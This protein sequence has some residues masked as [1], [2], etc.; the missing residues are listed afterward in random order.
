MSES[1][2]EGKEAGGPVSPLLLKVAALG[3]GGGGVYLLAG[4]RT[5]IEV[6]VLLMIVALAAFGVLLGSGP[7]GPAA[8]GALDLSARLGLGLLGGFLGALAAVAGR[9]VLVAAGLPELL[10][11]SLFTSWTAPALLAHLG[12]GV[13]WGMVLGIVFPY[14]PG[15][16]AAGQGALFS[17]VPSLYLL[18]KV[19]PI[20]RDLGVFG[21]ELGGLTFLFVIVLNVL[22]GAVAGGVVGWG[23]TSEEVPVARPIDA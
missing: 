12:S 8:E 16:T 14:V 3:L 20:D 10:G 1:M 6:G 2:A 17:L 18:L 11:V 7:Y 5:S 9:W 19:F 13:V 21:L 15:A 22:W 23:E 4:P